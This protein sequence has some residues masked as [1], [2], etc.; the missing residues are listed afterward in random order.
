M[1][2]QIIQ[3]LQSTLNPQ[4]QAQAVE[5]LKELE[6]APQYLQ[7][8]VKIVNE[9]NDPSNTQLLNLAAIYINQ[10]VRKP[11]NIDPSVLEGFRDEAMSLVSSLPVKPRKHIVT[12]LGRVLSYQY[13]DQWSTAPVEIFNAIQ[14]TKDL[15][16]LADYLDILVTGFANFK[17]EARSDALFAAIR[18]AIDVLGTPLIAILGQIGPSLIPGSEHGHFRAVCNAV[19]LCCLLCSRALSEVFESA[20]STTLMPLFEHVLAIKGNGS[21]VEVELKTA[22]VELMRLLVVVHSEFTSEI[23]PT[24]MTLTWNTI[25]SHAS[26][27]VSEYDPVVV[28]AVEMLA[29]VAS[30]QELRSLYDGE[31]VI[32]GV[33]ERVIIPSLGENKHDLNMIEMRDPQIVQS[34]LE[35]ANRL[36]RKHACQKLVRALA[37]NHGPKIVQL[38]S[39]NITRIVSSTGRTP[40]DLSSGLVLFA[41]SAV[42]TRSCGAAETLV[43][44]AQPVQFAHQILVPAMAQVTSGGAEPEAPLVIL[45]ADCCSFLIE[46]RRQLPPQFMCQQTLALMNMYSVTTHETVV[47]VLAGTIATLIREVG[48]SVLDTPDVVIPLTNALSA[49]IEV[50]PEMCHLNRDESRDQYVMKFVAEATSFAGPRFSPSFASML[51]AKE[52]HVLKHCV[53][54]DERASFVHELMEALAAALSVLRGHLEA[55]TE[56]AIESFDQAEAICFDVFQLVQQADQEEIMPFIFQLLSLMVACKR[57]TTS[58]LSGPYLGAFEA[59]VNPQN[60]TISGNVPA[61]AML[62]NAF[63]AHFSEWAAANGKMEVMLGCA[64]HMI[65]TKTNSHRGF[66]VLAVMLANCPDIVGNSFQQVFTAVL[67]KLEESGGRNFKM[68][69]LAGLFFCQSCLC[70]GGSTLLTSAMEVGGTD[71]LSNIVGL[72]SSICPTVIK[73]DEKRT[74]VMGVASFTNAI[75][76]SS[77]EA[78]ASLMTCI[79]K[80]FTGYKEDISIKTQRR[81]FLASVSYKVGFSRLRHVPKVSTAMMPQVT[82]I[83]AYLKQLLETSAAELTS[84]HLPSDSLPY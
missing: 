46:F 5:Q 30:S 4:L 41:A 63:A 38:A 49:S 13:P 39:A 68:Q 37:T 34:M 57:V 70:L 42:M 43:E 10:A 76:T 58:E 55:G 45:L 26:S 23:A 60:Y 8:L 22:V 1:D 79:A 25:L 40:A 48:A 83:N 11:K 31:G 75:G 81:S 12:A 20:I 21:T 36:T 16:I 28:S 73:P 69:R 59:A 44:G 80:I 32:E 51:V 77:A 35:D 74:Y 64:V 14:S 56:G 65:G 50:Y 2:A 33:F 61:L 19:R 3:F 29:E 17:I 67:G 82:D 27:D 54:T 78:R 9:H 66:N 53:A 24:S 18:A 62:I 15:D 72:L 6:K 47:P 84:L 7:T 71:L 52:T